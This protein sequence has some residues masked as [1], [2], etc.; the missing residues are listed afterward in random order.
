LLPKSFAKLLGSHTV[1]NGKFA[2]VALFTFAASFLIN[3]LS[4]RLPHMCIP[5][6]LSL[7]TLRRYLRFHDDFVLPVFA[8]ESDEL[9]WCVAALEAVCY[10]RGIAG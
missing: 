7:T 6:G 3:I 4:T 5:A 1:K 2:R 8:I 9:Q 10:E